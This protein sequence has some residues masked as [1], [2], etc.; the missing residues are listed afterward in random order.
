MVILVTD[1]YLKVQL[2]S[3]EG[4]FKPLLELL[5]NKGIHD[6]EI[7]W[8]ENLPLKESANRIKAVLERSPGPVVLIGHGKGGL[9]CLECL[10]RNPELRV[11]TKSLICIQSPFWGTPVADYLAGHPFVRLA[12]LALCGLLKAPFEALE[13]LSELNRQV[14]MIINQAEIESLM[15][16]VEIKTVGSANEELKRPRG[17]RA[18][19]LQRFSKVIYKYAG[20]NDGLVPLASARIGSEEHVAVPQLGH[21]E[22]ITDG[23]ALELVNLLSRPLVSVSNRP[24]VKG[25]K[26]LEVIE[27]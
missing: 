26:H 24:S 21:T 14:Y 12:T 4:Y 22:A 19:L 3:T 9:D 6:F 1:S 23:P 20:Q 2:P 16:E 18:A 13:E 27:I 25:G 10:I 11:K 5:G 8:S 17:F 15:G 7:I